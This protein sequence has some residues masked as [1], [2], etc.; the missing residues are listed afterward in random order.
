MGIYYTVL[1]AILMLVSLAL[2]PKRLML[3]DYG[4]SFKKSI[5]KYF[6]SIILLLENIFGVCFCV[7]L[8]SRIFIPSGNYYIMLGII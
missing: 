1:L 5:F 8:L 2:L 6:Y 7:Y 4:E 3:H